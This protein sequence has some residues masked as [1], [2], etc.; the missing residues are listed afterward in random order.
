MIKVALIG[1]GKMGHLI[2]EIAN[3]HGMEIVAKV[4]PFLLKNEITKE[5]V[6]NADVCIEFSQPDTVVQN[7]KKLIELK[8]NIVVG[9]TGWFSH[10]D[11]IKKLTKKNQTGFIYSSNFSL[12][13][14]I[15]FKIVDYATK[16]TSKITDYD[17]Y[18]FEKHHR[19]KMD[20]P[21]GTAKMLTDIVIKNSLIKD[22]PQFDKL[23]R[24]IKE[25]EFHFASIRA[26][27]IFGEHII[28][29]DSPADEITLSHRLKNRSGLAIGAI[30]AA[31]WIANKKG[32]YNFS[33]I[34]ENIIL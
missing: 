20:S 16:L 27:H 3:A 7:I 8:K 22:I 19:Q 33:E 18:G 31:K 1:Y 23:D 9:T 10:L 28:G 12:G 30:L 26:G 13:M 2:D 32:F 5:T 21:S 14:N 24:K 6:A 25:N 15:F 11:E 17:V 4:D 34:F 29:L